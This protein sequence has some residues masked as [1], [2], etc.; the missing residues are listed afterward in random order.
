MPAAIGGV[1]CEIASGTISMSQ[2]IKREPIQRDVLQLI[3]ELGLGMRKRGQRVSRRQREEAEKARR[4]HTPLNVMKRMGF[5]S[6]SSSADDLPP[7]PLAEIAFAG[8]SNVGKSS[9]LNA[10]TGKH[11]NN[12]GTIGIAAVKNRPGVTRSLNVYANP[13]GAQL[14]DLPGYGYA[15]ASEEEVAQWQA[16]MRDYLS[17]RG[18]Q[19]AGSG[20]APMI[21]TK[22]KDT[23]SFMRVI[24]VV[25][26]RQALKQSDK[27]FLLWLDREAR[28]PVHVV[29]SKCDL[30]APKELCRRYT[31]LGST[32]RD[33]QLQHHMPP[34]F[35]ISSKTMAGVD[36]LRATL[37]EAMPPSIRQRAEE[38]E[39]RRRRRQLAAEREREREELM[40]QV[41][42]PAARDFA[43]RLKAKQEARERRAPR[44]SERSSGL[45]P[46]R[47]PDRR[48]M[49]RDAWARR[50]KR[51]PRG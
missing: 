12:T 26:A 19:S 42:T 7:P 27:D 23:E 51:R 49:A 32:L 9:L 41:S 15:Q 4:E 13:L 33:L 6:A 22:P 17:R 20:A 16:A 28:V 38:A 37:S 40:E 5:Q 14:V 30:I 48:A 29:M 21:G 50:A 34:H 2:R 45:H 10:L 8:R 36:L 3:E 46:S 47:A 43:L 1:A 24:L 18:Q 44:S 11:C 31:I 35:M 39:D 25:D